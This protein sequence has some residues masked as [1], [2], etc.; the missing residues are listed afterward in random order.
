MT[1]TMTSPVPERLDESDFAKEDVGVAIASP[2]RLMWW[3][4]RKHRVAVFSL[5][6]LVILY[7]MAIFAGFLSPYDPN[8]YNAQYKFVPPMQITFIDGQGNFSLRPGV[9]KLVGD[10]DPDTL[11]ITYKTDASVVVSDSFLCEGRAV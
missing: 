9:Y 8:S 1:E 7:L 10:R 4:F 5:V 3:K 11:R 6:V 2:R